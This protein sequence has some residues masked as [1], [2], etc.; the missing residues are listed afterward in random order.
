MLLWENVLIK[1]Y[2]LR[3]MSKA[4]QEV[5]MEKYIYLVESKE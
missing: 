5:I 2:G 4:L 3:F 1:L